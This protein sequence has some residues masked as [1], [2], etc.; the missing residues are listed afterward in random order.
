MAEDKIASSP[1]QGAG[2]L[3]SGATVGW[4]ASEVGLMEQEDASSADVYSRLA[5]LDHNERMQAILKLGASLADK[6]YHRFVDLLVATLE[7]GTLDMTGW[8]RIAIR[9]ALVVCSERNLSVS[10]K[11]G[12]RVTSPVTYPK[13]GPLLDLF[14]E[15]IFSGVWG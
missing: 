15:S 7:D 4:G 11:N 13:E 5:S 6:D 1:S 9:A 3:N 14:V 2:F 8:N 12:E 10:F